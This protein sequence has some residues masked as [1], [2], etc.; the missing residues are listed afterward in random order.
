VGCAPTAHPSV[1]LVVKTEYKPNPGLSSGFTIGIGM[2]VH[3]VPAPF[4]YAVTAFPGHVGV[5]VRTRAMLQPTAHP[6]PLPVVVPK[7]STWTD[8]HTVVKGLATLAALPTS[9]ITPPSVVV[10]MVLSAPTIQPS[11]EFAK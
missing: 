11:F 9:Q 3:G 6:S 8:L 5:V 1:G 2:T 4:Q 7:V 10:M